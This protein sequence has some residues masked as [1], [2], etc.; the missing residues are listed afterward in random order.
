MP[1][2]EKQAQGNEADGCEPDDA[3][4]PNPIDRDVTT[5]P[6]GKTRALRLILAALG[7]MMTGAIVGLYFQPPL[8]QFIFRS[9]ALEPGAGTTT[10]IATPAPAGRAD[11]KI[12]AAGGSDRRF[13][14]GLGKIIPS[15]DVIVVSPPFGAADAR[16]ALLKVKQGDRVTM[17]ET[18]A[19]MDSEK[20][21]RAAIESARAT[22]EAR[23]AI[24]AQTL[25]SVRASRAEAGASLERAIATAKKAERDLDRIERL[26]AKGFATLAAL[27]QKRTTRDETAREI[28]RA[29][30]ALSRWDTPDASRQPDVVV[31]QRNLDTAKA[32]L[33]SAENDLDKAFVRAPISGT[34]LEIFAKVG[35]RPGSAGVMD[36]GDI[37]KMTVEIEV[38]QSQI[39]LVSQGAA[40][41]LTAEAFSKPLLATVS[42]IGLEVG[43]QVLVDPAP[44]ANTDARVIKV[45]ADLDPQ[46]S[47][48][49]RNYTNLQ[50]TARI[51]AASAP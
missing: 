42:R 16:I 12:M 9:L 49:A 2:T 11:D 17:G 22:V 10:P 18:L 7:L 21:Y 3:A 25:A 44:A 38:Y 50:V 33:L 30:A 43:R 5:T 6:S 8:L 28:E 45:Y 14:L 51:A 37:N 29:R 35:E 31:A 19:V 4:L 34:V 13:V 40:V 27:D 15:G 47:K 41:E 39:G 36:I 24:L 32:N 26:Y 1:N 20:Q 23:E 46:S 48:M